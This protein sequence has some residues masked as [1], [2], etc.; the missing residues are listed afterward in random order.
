MAILNIPSYLQSKIENR[1]S[2]VMEE[3]YIYEFIE[4]LIEINP[5]LTNI[6]L[7]N[8]KKIRKFIK[9]F[10]NG[11]DIRFLKNEN[12]FVNKDDEVTIL[13]AVAGG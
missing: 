9:I 3:G 12:S 6:L 8:N 13:T 5:E 1:S 11:K 10:I 2:I 4:R 7:D